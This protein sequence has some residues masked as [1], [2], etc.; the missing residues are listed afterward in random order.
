MNIVY[1]EPYDNWNWACPVE[2]AHQRDAALKTNCTQ[3]MQ[4]AFADCKKYNSTQSAVSECMRTRWLK[5]VVM[6]DAALVE[7]AQKRLKKLPKSAPPIQVN[8]ALMKKVLTASSKREQQASGS[9]TTMIAVAAVA[10]AALLLRAGMKKR[11]RL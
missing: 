8:A 11:W 2:F 5:H 6:L 7:A 1:P 9:S 3:L 4:A 10:V